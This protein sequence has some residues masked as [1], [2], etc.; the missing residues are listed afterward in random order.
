[1]AG[2]KLKMRSNKWLE[3]VF[4]N[5]LYYF[6]KIIILAQYIEGNWLGIYEMTNHN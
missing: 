2:G 3:A 5:C 1:V 6:S 4:E